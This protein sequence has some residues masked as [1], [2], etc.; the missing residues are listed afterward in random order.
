MA[1]TAYAPFTHICSLYALIEI[2]VKALKECVIGRGVIGYNNSDL[3]IYPPLSDNFK[4]G[5]R[6][7]LDAFNMAPFM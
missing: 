6:Q 3:N 1:V 7:I 4:R 5:A 2:L